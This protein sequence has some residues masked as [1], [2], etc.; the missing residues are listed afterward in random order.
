MKD[1]F[2]V[3][4]QIFP[5]RL[6]ELLGDPDAE[7]SDRVMRAMLEMGKIDLAALEQA[8]AGVAEPT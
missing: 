4:W 8:A 6:D 7:T 3:S 5:K 1:R 2:G